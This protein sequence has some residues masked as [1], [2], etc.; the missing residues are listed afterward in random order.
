M[1]FEKNGAKSRET[2]AVEKKF[3]YKYDFR[4]SLKEDSRYPILNYFRVERY[5]TRPLA[6]LIVKAVINTPIT[7]NQ[8]TVFSFFLGI[9]AGICLSLGKPGYFMA[10]GILAQLSSIFDCS[11]GMLARARNRCS[12]YGAYLD[13]FLDRFVDLF[14]LGG[15]ATGY[16]VY[17][18]DLTFFIVSIFGVALYFL[19]VSLYYLT[20]I[21]KKNTK[22]GEAAE[23][24]GLYIFLLFVFS[25]ANQMKLLILIY[26]TATVS[27]NII[28]IINLIRLGILSKKSALPPSQHGDQ[29][30]P[31]PQEPQY[32]PEDH[33]S[34]AEIHGNTQ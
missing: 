5:F 24:R 22:F 1:K 33:Q 34:H 7:P 16:F 4:K 19:Q 20:K 13:L 28:K 25:L 15:G 23:A 9:C 2:M 6:S 27:N 10:G 29:T 17:S 31:R 8:I 3:T 14:L 26:L 11:D 30:D 12:D 32:A 21:Y 18:K